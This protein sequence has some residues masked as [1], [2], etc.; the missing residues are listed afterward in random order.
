[1]ISRRSLQTLKV[2]K[3]DLPASANIE[4]ERVSRE[5]MEARKQIRDLQGKIQKLGEELN[6]LKGT[7]R[8]VQDK[9]LHTVKLLE[10]RTTGLKGAQTFLT[11][12]DRYAGAEIMKMVEPLNLIAE[13]F[14]GELSFL[15]GNTFKMDERRRNAQLMLVCH[16]VSSYMFHL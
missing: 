4:R 1:V 5:Q 13:T 2:E 7:L 9:N 10:E 16:Q 8:G 12:D 11:T 15:N 6:I 14:Q 3:D